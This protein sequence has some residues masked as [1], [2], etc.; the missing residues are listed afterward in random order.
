MRIRKLLYPTLLL[1][2]WIGL[3]DVPQAPPPPVVEERDSNE[4]PTPA[5]TVGPQAGET[6]YLIGDPSDEEQ[7][8]LELVNQAR[9]NPAAEA[10][11]LAATTDPDILSAY[12]Y[13]DVDLAK[14]VADTSQYPVAP[15]LA[16]EPRLTQAAR[17]HSAWMLERGVQSHNESNPFNTPGDRITAAG[18]PWQ[19]YGESIYAYAQHPEHGHAG[20]EVDWGIG[21]GGMQ[22]PPGHRNSNHNLAFREAGIG[23]IRGN[24]PNNTGPSVVTI[25]FGARQTP[26]PLVTGVA[27]YDL[28][29]NGRYDMGEG[30][31][32]LSVQVSDSPSFAIT[33]DSGGYAVPS[34]NG[35]RTVTFSGN[36]LA[37][38]TFNRTL[39]NGSNV[40]VDLVLPYVAPSVSGPAH[41]PAGQPAVFTFNPVPGAVS[42]RW[43]QATVSG[44]PPTFD[45]S[46]GLTGLIVAAAGTPN[47]LV[48]GPGGGQAYHLTHTL[49]ASTASMEFDVDLRPREQS[50][51]RFLSRLGWATPQQVA[52]VQVMESGSGIW[53]SVWTQAG[54]GAAGETTYTLRTVSLSAYSGKIIRVRVLYSACAGCSLYP[55]GDDGIGF[56]F[57]DVSFTNTDRLSFSAPNTV[58]S[59]TQF[60]FTP[61]ASGTYELSVQP[62]KNRGTL[63]FGNAWVVDTDAIAIPT[64]TV[65]GLVS[66]PNGQLRVDF[67]VTGTLTGTP[68]LLSAPALGAP[69]VV[70]AAKLLT[71]TPTSF[72]FQYTPTADRGFLKV[73]IP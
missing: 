32:G 69:Y 68:V 55:Q 71:N 44:T 12:D 11:R 15:P 70:T 40:K 73:Q 25:N 35:S 29:S 34:A 42:Y 58:V 54:S 41:T 8:Y 38:Q 16:F 22:N 61:P 5:R 60:S 21:P 17:G 10:Q 65:N 52:Q 49:Q 56:H 67:V 37:P 30:I 57:D 66:G 59:G 2:C 7:M 53:S 14:F 48:S 36:G 33:T 26:P 64:V 6:Q 43:R 19:T 45:G 50:A 24:G 23:V 1:P 62:V 39:A 3:G 28:N 13:F 9:A 63:P 51:M 46:A 20:F 27:Y 4:I 18:Y 31:G 72:S 47:P